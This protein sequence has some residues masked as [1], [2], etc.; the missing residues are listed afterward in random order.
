MTR[1]RSYLHHRLRQP[2]LASSAV[3]RPH[4]QQQFSSLRH[5]FGRSARG[6]TEE[7]FQGLHRVPINPTDDILASE[8]ILADVARATG[9]PLYRLLRYSAGSSGRTGILQ[10]ILS[11]LAGERVGGREARSIGK[12]GG[13]VM[14][15]IQDWL[16]RRGV[17]PRPVEPSPGRM[18]GGVA[19]PP[20]PPGEPPPAAGG[21]GEGP[22][23]PRASK[24]TPQREQQQEI[25]TPQSSNVFSFSYDPEGSILY[26][27]FKGVTVNHQKV[28]VQA[29]RQGGRAHLHGKLGQTVSGRTNSRGSMYAY[30]DVPARVFERMKRA[31][32]KGKFVWDELRVRGTVYGH[33]YRY[34]LVQAQANVSQ[35]HAYVPRRATK[36]GFR[37]RSVADEG[38]GRRGY[39]SSTLKEQRFSGQR[40][41]GIRRGRR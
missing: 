32:S 6:D 22:L 21:P 36:Q 19:P 10:A 24:F 20:T 17:V 16:V 31:V 13:N 11:A 37:V 33:Q 2:G 40:G 15:S 30:L 1:Q 14:R 29:G 18:G 25:L 5:G 38:L 23:P 4:R 41:G 35:G 27:T 34:M 28:S 26:V 3:S 9:I 8:Q 39:I 7:I 12:M